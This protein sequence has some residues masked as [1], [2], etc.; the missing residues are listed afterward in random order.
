MFA[1]SSWARRDCWKP[2]S[3]IEQAEVVSRR[4]GSDGCVAVNGK[5]NVHIE[6]VFYSKSFLKDVCEG[7]QRTQ[8]ENSPTL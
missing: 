7:L 1:C 5:H 2:A 6:A 8:R 3:F 4:D